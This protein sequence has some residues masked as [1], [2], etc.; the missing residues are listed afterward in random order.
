MLLLERTF[1]LKY[2]Q[3]Y[4]KLLLNLNKIKIIREWTVSKTFDN[5]E[6][7]VIK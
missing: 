2:F 5:S 6:Y 4:F 7:S 1:I 3:I